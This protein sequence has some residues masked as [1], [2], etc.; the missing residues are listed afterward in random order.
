M[1]LL[2]YWGKELG[3]GR[4]LWRREEAEDKLPHMKEKILPFWKWPSAEGQRG[5]S[6]D[7]GKLLILPGLHE[8][9]QRCWEWH[10]ANSRWRIERNRA[11]AQWLR[12]MNNSLWMIHV[13]LV[14]SFW[15]GTD[16]K[17]NRTNS[18]VKWG[19]Q[20][21]EFIPLLWLTFLKSSS[22]LAELC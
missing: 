1:L 17:P 16:R 12:G 7:L 6:V 11:F 13:T 8:R 2:V 4:W 14:K 15:K 22:R 20:D 3:P 9:S 21:S 5:L 10:L 19:K 18:S